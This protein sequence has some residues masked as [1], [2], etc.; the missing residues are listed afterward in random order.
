LFGPKRGFK[1]LERR[2]LEEGDGK[3]IIRKRMKRRLVRKRGPK[4]KTTVYE[5]LHGRLKRKFWVK[6]LEEEGGGG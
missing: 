3:K 1:R 5:V 2:K 6:F 4:K